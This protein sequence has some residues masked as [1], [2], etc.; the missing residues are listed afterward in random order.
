LYL[1]YRIEKS[2]KWRKKSCTQRGTAK[3]KCCENAIKEYNKNNS[4]S[5]LR[6]E[7]AYNKSRKQIADNVVDDLKKKADEAYQAAKAAGKTG[8]ALRQVWPSTFFGSAN[9]VYLKADVVRL[10][11][12]S[13][14]PT[15][16]NVEAAYD[17]K[18]NCTNNGKMDAKQRKK[19]RKIFGKKK[20]P[21]KL[22]HP[23]GKE[24]EN[25]KKAKEF[26]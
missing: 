23:K 20:S 16:S 7:V 5:D 24:C 18:F 22:I 8:K 4:N 21:P 10:K 26:S 1:I 14:P 2:S 3:H 15:P 25:K 6:S 17:F 19:Y 12:P 13:K 9:S 11:E